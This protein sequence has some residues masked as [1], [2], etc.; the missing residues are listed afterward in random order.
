VALL[1]PAAIRRGRLWLPLGAAAI[2]A[3]LT[4]APV[5]VSPTHGGFLWCVA[6][7]ELGGLDV[8][9]NLLLFLP[10]GAAL[11][12]VG[13][14]WRRAGLT[15]LALSFTI[16][17]LQL[18][19]IPGRD[20]S[21]SDILTNSAGT[22]AG[23]WL[24]IHARSWLAPSVRRAR[25]WTIATAAA[26]AVLLALTAALLQLSVPA[27]TLSTEWAPRRW[28]FTPFRGQID[29]VDLNGLPLPSGPV[30]QRAAY[31]RELAAG[32]LQLDADVTTGPI[33]PH[34]VAPVVRLMSGDAELME[35]AQRGQ[36]LLFRVRFRSAA[37]RFRT[38][39][40][41]LP[42]AVPGPGAA[43]RVAG[44]LERRSMT[45]EVVRDGRVRRAVLDLSPALGWA[46]ILPMEIPLGGWA[47]ALSHLWLLVVAFPIGFYGAG[48]VGKTGTGSVARFAWLFA[49]VAVLAASLVATP[50]LGELA[51]LAWMDWAGAAAG[52]IL[53]AAS[54]T[55]TARWRGRLADLLRPPLVER[56][57]PAGRAGF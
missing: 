25:L 45:A 40:L 26:A 5:P 57:G 20:S 24:V 10:M 49:P 44:L 18:G 27:G 21:L 8:F 48:A 56:A 4:L 41:V 9:N 7:G 2:I 6:C 17:M 37:F 54:W 50:R 19:W 42:N 36:D 12:A 43:A 28:N 55:L 35:L 13:L 14:D 34:G 11:A 46:F 23:A 1:I 15:G 52:A 39:T 33:P 31:D 29:R 22:L 38:L 51:P 16:E 53:G 3:L 30:P 32:W 47:A